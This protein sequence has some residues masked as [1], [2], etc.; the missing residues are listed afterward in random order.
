MC[1]S[2]STRKPWQQSTGWH[3]HFSLMHS[4]N[5][6]RRTFRLTR[7]GILFSTAAMAAACCASVWDSASASNARQASSSITASSLASGCVSL[8][9]WYAR[10]YTL[11]TCNRFRSGGL[12]S[13]TAAHLQGASWAYSTNIFLPATTI[14]D[15]RSPQ[16]L[17]R[18]G[19][20]SKGC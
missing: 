9:L 6:S 8:R 18:R 7:L 5:S 10:S 2:D 11:Q 20:H 19:H 4:N 12:H 14:T 13:R 3:G 16:T 1:R 17:Q 15:K